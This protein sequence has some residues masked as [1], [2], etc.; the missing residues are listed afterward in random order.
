MTFQTEQESFWAGD[1]GDQYI[2][3]S[4]SWDH[5]R[6]RLGFL[7]R[8]LEHVSR[9]ESVIEFG[10]NIGHNLRALRLLVP[11][12]KL[13]AI[14]INDKACAE[15]NKLNLEEVYHQSILDFQP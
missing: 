1:F 3:R 7:V 10:A 11:T 15:L 5:T 13:S 4:L 14:E 8:V 2:E 12:A 9:L 6:R